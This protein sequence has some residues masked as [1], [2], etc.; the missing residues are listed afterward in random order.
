MILSV[1]RRVR[2]AAA[3]LLLAGCAGGPGGGDVPLGEFRA[4]GGRRIVLSRSSAAPVTYLAAPGSGFDPLALRSLK[5]VT[6]TR[7]AGTVVAG[8]RLVLLVHG[9]TPGCPH[10][11]VLLATNF[12]VTAQTALPDCD[13]SFAIAARPGGDVVLS[14]T[15]AKAPIAYVFRDDVLYGPEREQRRVAAR[16][17]AAA[18]ATASPSPGPMDASGAPVDL[19]TLPLPATGQG[20]DLDK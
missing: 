9:A 8:N 11:Y 12:P 7:V 16:P 3:V 17:R 13:K 10:R 18:P 20:V 6:D 4:P 1:A 19:D 15:N 2:A 14:Q 5:G